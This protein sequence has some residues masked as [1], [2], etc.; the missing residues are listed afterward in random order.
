MLMSLS[1]DNA[2]PSACL[3]AHFIS[4][5]W[6]IQGLEGYCCLVSRLHKGCTMPAK[7]MSSVAGNGQSDQGN[8]VFVFAMAWGRLTLLS[9]KACWCGLECTGTGGRTV[10]ERMVHWKIACIQEQLR[11]VVCWKQTQQQR[12]SWS[13]VTGFFLFIMSKSISSQI[14]PLLVARLC[15][16][17]CK[18]E[19]WHASAAWFLS[20]NSSVPGR[21]LVKLIPSSL[22]LGMLLISKTSESNSVAFSLLLYFP[23]LPH[24][25]SGE[26]KTAGLG[27]C[28]S[29]HVCI[30]NMKEVIFLRLFSVGSWW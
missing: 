13:Y 21:V 29:P 19:P 28:T 6:C 11:A 15:E 23:V 25:P 27:A 8:C 17:P 7:G 9:V 14:K 12:L 20:F 10:S 3:P 2:V 30:L 1:G 16:K 18:A 4:V 22:F 26:P 24:A 5:Q